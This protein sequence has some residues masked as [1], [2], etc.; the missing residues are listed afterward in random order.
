M[1]AAG[2]QRLRDR[3]PI[4]R[5]VP[6]MTTASQRKL[7]STPTATNSRG[8]MH[9]RISLTSLGTGSSDT[10]DAGLA[11]RARWQ[12]R[13]LWIT[14][15]SHIIRLILKVQVREKRPA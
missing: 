12:N 5:L 8:R 6:T 4:W 15:R 13:I 10:Q 3:G 1:R 9:T 7:G 14:V 11:S 2:Y